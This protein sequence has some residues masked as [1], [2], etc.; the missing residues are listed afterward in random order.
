MKKRLTKYNEL[1]NK[2]KILKAKINK[3]QDKKDDVFL[4][5]FTTNAY[6]YNARSIL[7]VLLEKP[8]ESF[9]SYALKYNDKFKFSKESMEV[10]F[11]NI[12]RKLKKDNVIISLKKGL[13]KLN[14]KEDK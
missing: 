13:Y 14:I 2:I 9:T 5:N 10:Q 1:D 12:I 6:F 4:K 7:E 11:T 8:N 3:L